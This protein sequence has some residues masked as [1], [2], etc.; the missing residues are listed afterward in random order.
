M[1]PSTYYAVLLALVLGV[2]C[3]ESKEEKAA[4]AK[5]A[6][7][8]KA[9]ARVSDPNDSNEVTVSQASLFEEAL[10]VS[11]LLDPKTDLDVCQRV[12]KTRLNVLR[13]ALKAAQEKRGEEKLTPLQT[14]KLINKHLLVDQKVS[15]LSNKYW[16]DSLFTSALLKKRGN[17]LSTSLLYY[18]LAKELKLPITL[19]FA[20][21]HAFVRWDDG[22]E[23]LNIETT[24][25]G[26]VFHDK[27]ALKAMDLG[28]EDLQP[29]GFFCKLNEKQIR[30]SLL[31]NWAGI[32]FTMERDA[33]AEAMLKRAKALTPQ[34]PDHR[35]KEAQDLLEKGKWGEAEAIFEK[36]RLTAKGPWARA[37]LAL[38]YANAL[39][40]RGKFKE[41]IQWLETSFDRAPTLMKIRMVSQLGVLYRHQ[42]DFDSAIKFHKLQAK[43]DPG[44]DS[45]SQLGSVLTEAHRD[46][47]AIVA[48]E[49]SLKYN[50]ED[51]FCKVILSGLYERTGDRDKGRSLFA[52]IE[53]P[54][55]KL[56]TW[57]CALV[58]YYAVVKEKK[59]LLKHMEAALKI[60]PSGSTYLYFVREP[61]MDPY[62]KDAEFIELMRAYAPAALKTDPKADTAPK[63][64]PKVTKPL[65]EEE[66]AKI[67]ETA[68]RKAIKKPTGELTKADLEKVTKLILDN[69]QLTDVTA[70]KELT[71][72]TRLLL[73]GNRLTDVTVLK[74]LTQLTEVNLTRNQLTS[75]KGLE[76][77]TKLKWLKLYDNKLTSVKVL[78]KLTQLKYLFLHDNQLTSVK[79]LEKLTQLKYLYLMYNQLTSVKGLEKLT[80]LTRLHLQGNP[81][82]T[83]AQIDQLKKALPKCEIVSDHD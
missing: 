25:Q 78:E 46:R 60:D 48:Y 15:Y 37:R 79:G 34:N 77:L 67:I 51:F 73:S 35:L 24:N 44:E 1:P 69:N 50:P 63:A 4:K 6:A 64:E 61:D 45:Y 70:L 30:A 57:Y 38:A 29:N 75:V 23:I 2:G 81:A 74:E 28:P 5:A 59:M 8:A 11:K 65:T 43:L 33:E 13:E 55:A 42:R 52:K 32:L 56:S 7:A 10:T 36:L 54:R 26:Q 62:R 53:T 68:I 82:L 9:D 49:K 12:W 20:P 21:S 71:Q 27:G 72:L 14:I 41:A 19:A 83:K 80:Q 18:L 31:V 17:C 16:R 66:S 47:E 3:E 58:W 22:K 39:E 76:K 40:L